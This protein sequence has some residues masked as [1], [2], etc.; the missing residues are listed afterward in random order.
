MT[1]DAWKDLARADARKRGLDDLVP[2]IDTLGDAIQAVRNGDWNQDPRDPVPG[3]DGDASQAEGGSLHD[4]RLPRGHV[5]DEP[6]RAD[7]LPA[8][9]VL[10]LAQALRAGR[11]T[12]QEVTEACLG[13]IAQEHARLN[14]FVTVTAALARA[15]AREADAKFARGEVDSPLQGV[16]ISLKDLLALEGVPTTAASQVRRD[17]IAPRDAVVVGRLK[18]AGAVIVGTC[19][20]HEFA[21]GTTSEDSAYGP[22]RHPLDPD[23]SPGGSSGGSAAAVA[24]GLCAASVGTDTG[25]SIRIPAAACGIVGLKPM[26]GELSCRGVVPLSRGLDHVGP[27]TSTVADAWLL[28]NIM[29]GLALPAWPPAARGAA[30]SGLTVGIPRSYFLDLLDVEVRAQ[31]DAALVRLR[32]GGVGVVEVAIPHAAQIAPIYLLI[33]FA[34]AAAY[35]G[36]GLDACADRYT[37]PVRSRLELSRY[38]L[39]EDY[40]RAQV[41]RDVLRH[42]VGAALAECDVLALPTLPIPA[43]RIGSTSVQV[44]SGRLPVRAATLRLTQLFNLTGHPAISIPSGLTRDGWPTGLQVVGRLG[45]TERLLAIASAMET[46]A[47]G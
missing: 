36:P 2:M 10:G 40:V 14:A 20:L 9:S 26:Y 38:V 45:G 30:L 17:A 3:P 22:V 31:Y 16:P 39:G 24:A 32:K 13:R 25:G 44:G 28:Y 4:P 42:E 46:L 7:H 37:S 21:F 6:V 41:G 18:E 35:H 47:R 29:R 33:G 8:R 19:N 34:E 27:I 12:S 1:L 15:Q 5:A 43:P 23:H 11:T